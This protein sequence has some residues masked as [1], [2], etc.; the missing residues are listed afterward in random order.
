MILVAAPRVENKTQTSI[1]ETRG[2][3]IASNTI[4]FL[5]DENWK[6]ERRK[7]GNRKQKTSQ[8]IK[9]LKKSIFAAT[10]EVVRQYFCILIAT[11]TMVASLIE[12]RRSKPIRSSLWVRTGL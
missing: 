7:G 3:K 9:R 8:R 2:D 11:A 4:G 12:A 1:L 5:S 10:A 6:V